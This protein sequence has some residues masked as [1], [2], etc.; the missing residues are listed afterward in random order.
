MMRY[1]VEWAGDYFQFFF[2][3]IFNYS[4]FHE[5]TEDFKKK[6]GKRGDFFLFCAPLPLAAEVKIGG[7]DAG[8]LIRRWWSKTKKNW[9][10]RRDFSAA[11][12]A[13]PS[14]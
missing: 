11:R 4:D 2:V 7:S 12:T 14:A 8:K 10:R 6:R 9:R 13:S 1:Q 3:R 5:A